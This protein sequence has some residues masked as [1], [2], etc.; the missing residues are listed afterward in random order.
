[1]VN[2]MAFRTLPIIVA[3]TSALVGGAL[4]TSA[5]GIVEPDTREYG[6][7]VDS[8]T[9]P[10]VAARGSMV[11]Q[12]L[13]GMVGSNGCS[14]VREVRV[15]PQGATTTVEVRALYRPVMCPQMLIFLDGYVVRLLVPNTPTFTVSVK[16]PDG[17]VLTRVLTVE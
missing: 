1:M 2:R 14:S 9:G 17:S 7:R 3:S 10:L 16:Q 12:R 8:I 4:F 15:V 6:V 5:C 11:E 13:Y